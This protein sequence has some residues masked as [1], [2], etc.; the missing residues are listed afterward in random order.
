[1]R[2][3]ICDNSLSDS[4][5]QQFDDGSW[6]PCNTCLKVALD[7]AF[8]DGFEPNDGEKYKKST[9]LEEE[10]DAPDTLVDA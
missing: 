10:D 5:I 2:C 3:N 4:E 7:A 1:M 6:E 8:S 9:L